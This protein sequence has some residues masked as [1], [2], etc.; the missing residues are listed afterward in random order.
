MLTMGVHKISW[1]THC[2]LVVR[3][4]FALQCRYAKDHIKLVADDQPPT[5]HKPAVDTHLPSQSHSGKEVYI[6]RS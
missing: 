1:A 4:P 2:S 5:R 3:L 6:F